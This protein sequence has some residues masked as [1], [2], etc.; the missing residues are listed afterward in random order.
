MILA[1]IVFIFILGFLVFIHELGHFVVAKKSGIKVEEFGIGFPPRIWGKKKGET[2]YSINAI[3]IGGFVK[4][5]GEDKVDEDCLADPLS[6]TAKPLWVRSLVISAGVV[7]NFLVA[8]IIFYFL[9]ANSGFTNQQYLLFDYKFPFGEQQNFP[10]IS[11]IAENSPAEK[12][13]LKPNSIIISGNGIRFGSSKQFVQFINENK[14]EE[15]F[16]EV[17]SLSTKEVKKVNV[18]PRIDSPEG[19][20]ALGV[21]LG[22]IAE[23]RYETIVEKTAVGFLHAFDLTHYSIVSLGHLIKISF[24]QRTIK[25]LSS[26]VAGP[27]GILAITKITLKGGII[28][29]LNLMALISLALAMV[30]ILPFPALDGGRLALMG[31]EGLTKKKIPLKIERN[32]NLIGFVLLILLLVLVTYKDIVQF[33]DVL[34]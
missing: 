15:V 25:P 34:F 21:G 4:L 31:F 33:K 17:K 12:V 32:I 6:F 22:D 20:G 2:I 29:I 10:F 14:G 23:I 9:L 13:G 18:V 5:Y 11:L 7:M 30:N 3:P 24:E 26:S 16:L 19:Q 28:A 27:V 8:V 1:I